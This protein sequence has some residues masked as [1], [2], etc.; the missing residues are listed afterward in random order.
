VR[1]AIATVLISSMGTLAWAGPN[2]TTGPRLT[3]TANAAPTSRGAPDPTS[4]SGPAPATPA[5]APSGV[6]AP[7]SSTCA[8]DDPVPTPRGWQGWDRSA[9]VAWQTVEQAGGVVP[10]IE[11]DRTQAPPAWWRYPSA[12]RS[13]TLLEAESKDTA[14][15]LY[16]A[17]GSSELAKGDILVRTRGA[18]VCGKMAVLGGQVDGQW[19]TIEVGPD[20]K[21]PAMRPASAL[22][23]ATDG[24]ILLPDVLGFRI[25]VKKE[26]TIGHIRELRRDLD[27]L[28]RTVGKRPAL[29]APG[30]EAKEVVTERVH[31]L[32]DEAWSLGA[33]E[34]YDID[35]RELA[36]RALALGA[37]LGW[38]AAGIAAQAVLDDVVK[39]TQ[40]RPSVATA[41]ASLASFLAADPDLASPPDPTIRYIATADEV[42]FES[43][44][45]GFQIRWPITWRLLGLSANVETGVLANLTTGRVLL[46]DGHAD[47]GAAVLLAQ[48]P[49]GI[50][51]RA[52]L[53]RDGARK[54]FPA[55]KM[56]PLPAIVPAS[57]HEQFR[58]RREGVPRAG[59]V[60]TIDR[61]GVVTF[62]VLNAPGD[63]YPKLRDQYASFVRSLSALSTAPGAPAR[64]GPDQPRTVRGSTSRSRDPAPP[65]PR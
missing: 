64:P 23:F 45:L 6:S 18:G 10:E 42:G 33:D 22:F 49:A 40:D 38:P 27:H 34:T 61:G 36:G 52:T 59:E 57:R 19:I 29:L 9:V 35:R 56:K 17:V 37:H 30:D 46:E 28:E 21:T 1:A 11:E 7:P 4:G 65:P 24:Q 43:R 60:T 50:S 12:L 63:V 15:G 31:D 41:R 14:M 58:E 48:R 20:G 16:R 54:M 44:D 32:I 55:A 25:R 2:G 5:V 47:R 53:V 62:L 3:P 8:Q 51:A 13:K 26:E 39:K